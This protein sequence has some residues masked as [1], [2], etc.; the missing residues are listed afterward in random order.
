MTDKTL[1][2]ICLLGQILTASLTYLE[3][4]KISYTLKNRR[5]K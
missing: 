3:L 5:F 2:I 1:I 4:S